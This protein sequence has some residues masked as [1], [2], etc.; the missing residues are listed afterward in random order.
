[1]NDE[2]AVVDFESSR[3][4]SCGEY[5]NSHYCVRCRAR[6]LKASE[7][8]TVRFVWMDDFGN[9]TKVEEVWLN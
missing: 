5:G 6:E 9:I 1:M 8:A 3:C 2:G 4:L 7:K